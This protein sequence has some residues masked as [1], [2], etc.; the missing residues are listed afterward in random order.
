MGNW[1]SETVKVK[2]C[3]VGLDNSGKSTILNNMKPAEVPFSHRVSD[4]SLLLRTSIVLVLTILV[5]RLPL[6]R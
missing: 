2:V 3:V 6:T 4:P 5:R 1:F